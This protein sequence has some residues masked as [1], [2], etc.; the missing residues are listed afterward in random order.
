[1]LGQTVMDVARDVAHLRHLL[2]KDAVAYFLVE[3]AGA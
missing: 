1:M 2:H 3:L